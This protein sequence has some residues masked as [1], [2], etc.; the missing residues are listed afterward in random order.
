MFGKNGNEFAMN[1]RLEGAITGGTPDRTIKRDARLGVGYN[2]WMNLAFPE[3]KRRHSARYGM[4]SA[5]LTGKLI[6]YP[7]KGTDARLVV[8]WHRM[9]SWIGHRG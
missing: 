3:Q 2:N 4:F 7:A 5:A 8:G 1:C 9:G 6:G